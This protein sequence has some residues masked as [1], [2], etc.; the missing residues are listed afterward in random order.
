[1]W[2]FGGGGRIQ[3]GLERSDECGAEVVL[4]SNMRVVDIYCIQP[5]GIF[6]PWMA[7]STNG[8]QQIKHFQKYITH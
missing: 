6:H 2:G 3:S 5:I 7:E 1:M 8:M 4:V